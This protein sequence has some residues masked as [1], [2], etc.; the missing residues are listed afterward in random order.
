MPTAS[1]AQLPLLCGA[2]GA[3]AGLLVVV[4]W[5][6]SFI[7]KACYIEHQEVKFDNITKRIRVLCSGLDSKYVDAVPITQKVIEGVLYWDFHV[8]D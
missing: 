6:Y 4:W 8:R 2:G 1:T 7:F 5:W 3:C